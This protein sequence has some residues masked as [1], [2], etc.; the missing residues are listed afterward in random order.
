M[1]RGKVFCTLL[2]GLSKSF[3]CLSNDLLKAQLNAYGF[4]LPA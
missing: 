3:D 1:D 2:T 4:S